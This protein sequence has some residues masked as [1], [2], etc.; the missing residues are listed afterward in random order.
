MERLVP[1]V[2]DRASLDRIARP[3][4]ALAIWWRRMSDPL[5][6]ALQELDLARLD[7]LSVEI[8]AGGSICGALRAAG[9][10]ETAI[11]LL[12]QDIELLVKRHAALTGEDR[13]HVRLE[14]VE[15]DA[16]CQFHADDITLR[17]TC[18]YVGPGRQWCCVAGQDAICE[19]PTGS[20]G[21]FKG[22]MLLDP[23]AVLHRSPAM[24]AK[25]GRR[26]ELVIDPAQCS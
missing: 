9:Y 18:T 17:L 4:A 14:V 6:A 23:P 2:P 15:A 24:S 1:I 26:L 3:D 20:V 19:V 12:S 11:G 13:L 8:D 7:N 21:V 16:C 25:G 5:R 22:R 10:S